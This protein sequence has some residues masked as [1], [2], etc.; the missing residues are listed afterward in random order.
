MRVAVGVDAGASLAKLA[1]QGREPG[2]GL[3]LLP[4]S[5][6]ERILERIEELAADRIGLTGA[7]AALLGRSLGES[8]VHVNEFAAWGNGAGALLHDQ[9]GGANEPYLLVSLGTGTSVMLCDGLA[10]NRIGGTALG[11]GT[12]LGL[13]ALLFGCRE[14]RALADLAVRGDRREVDLLVSD[15][16]K[17]GEIPLAGDLTAACFGKPALRD[18]RTKPRQED[19]AQALMGLVGENV[20]LLCVG[21]AAAAPQ[22][23]RVVFGGSTLRSNPTLRDI[24]QSITAALG[25]DVV[26]LDNGEFAGAIGAL[27]LASS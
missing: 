2:L 17:P 20:A 6:P 15:I 12:M 26:F 19:L 7:G 27:R 11:G 24:L 13:S 10:V 3:E 14:F 22:A 18:P 4:A 8:T 9:A 21:L 16:Y 5:Q 1:I 23:R 25:R